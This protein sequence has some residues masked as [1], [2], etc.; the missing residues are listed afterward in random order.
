MA[1]KKHKKKDKRVLTLFF[2]MVP[3]VLLA[4]CSA[5]TSFYVRIFFQVM[6]IFFQIVIF[7]NFIDDYYGYSGDEE[8]D[9]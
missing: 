1:E 2:M 9:E 5:I 3:S 8:E 7:K 4:M 6:L